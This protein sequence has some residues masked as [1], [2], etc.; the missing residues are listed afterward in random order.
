MKVL[1]KIAVVLFTSVKYLFLPLL[2]LLIFLVHN[3]AIF[4]CALILQFVTGLGQLCISLYKTIESYH[5]HKKVH[6]LLRRYWLMVGLYFLSAC[7]CAMCYSN[8][9][10]PATYFHIYVKTFVVIAW[11]IASFYFNRIMPLK[12]GKVEASGYPANSEPQ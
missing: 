11:G 1:G 8:R 3:P 6:K 7:A 2:A 9:I 12:P 4:I 5:A 10:L